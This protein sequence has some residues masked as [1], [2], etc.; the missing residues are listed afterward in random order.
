MGVEWDS[1]K[2][3]P[4]GEFLLRKRTPSARLGVPFLPWA[5][6]SGASGPLA[7]WRTGEGPVNTTVRDAM[8]RT[9]ARVI[10]ELR[11]G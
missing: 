8:R 7:A 2:R 11:H 5:V 9:Q 1:R 10:R 4:Q 3:S 6:R